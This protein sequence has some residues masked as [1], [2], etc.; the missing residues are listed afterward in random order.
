[1]SEAEKRL[2]EGQN[3]IYTKIGQVHEM[4]KTEAE[5]KG[6]A[7]QK[8]A[9]AEALRGAASSVQGLISSFHKGAKLI[10]KGKS[11]EGSAHILRGVSSSVTLV[12]TV[13]KFASLLP[14]PAGTVTAAIT[15]LLGTVSTI[16]DLAAPVEA[17]SADKMRDAI[18]EVLTAEKAKEV[19]QEI[20]ADLNN[21]NAMLATIRPHAKRGKTETSWSKVIDLGKIWGQGGELLIL[22][23]TRNWLL[24]PDNHDL[25]YWEKVFETY[26]LAVSKLLELYVCS[27]S[28]LKW[29]EAAP[30]ADAEAAFGVI[31]E[32]CFQLETWLDKI[33]PAMLR[34]ARVWMLGSNRLV[35]SATKA[36][37]IG[38]IV[39]GIDTPGWSN[40]RLLRY[41]GGCGN[42]LSVLA[43]G[44]PMATSAGNRLWALN[45]ESHRLYTI[46]NA[47]LVRPGNPKRREWES[48]E[49]DAWQSLENFES[50]N[51]YMLKHHGPKPDDLYP[52][53]G[54]TTAGAGP[55]LQ[56]PDKLGDQID[57]FSVVLK[58]DDIDVSEVHLLRAGRP[59]YLQWDE[60]V[61]PDPADPWRKLVSRTPRYQF[62]APADRKFR[63]IA[64]APNGHLYLLA[65]NGGLWYCDGQKTHQIA[66]PEGSGSW[67]GWASRI[68]AGR[69]KI[70]V[71]GG[72][73]IIWKFHRD[74]TNTDVRWTDIPAPAIHG[75]YTWISEVDG[76][77]IVT[78]R[79]ERGG[80]VQLWSAGGWT[81]SRQRFH[82]P[83]LMLLDLCIARAPG[84]ELYDA[85]R[86]LIADLRRAAQIVQP[87][88]SHPLSKR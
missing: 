50:L 70:Y 67:P 15:G 34:R 41:R 31:N 58:D 28:V 14:P 35:D 24:E 80:E 10:Q 1:M 81:A 46:S 3:M 23:K 29:D 87:N 74:V 37:G 68:A 5:K 65:V 78:S 19:Y 82:Q 61:P 44:K 48:K 18:K 27:L 55:W 21:L 69:T 30:S 84:A 7:A 45:A 64:A 54:E 9:P 47:Y 2:R 57:D 77:A 22:N 17:D 16:L 11:V 71:Y 4:L 88:V 85:V 6:E 63:G 36:T 56:L 40:P 73:R 26:L 33:V 60:N 51:Q 20:E 38:G 12:T 39:E 59:L 25:P 32:T 76:G 66:P 53:Q 86:D 62:D 52:E 79:P 83:L 42:L 8:D 13:G 75:D 43:A 49:A 72:R